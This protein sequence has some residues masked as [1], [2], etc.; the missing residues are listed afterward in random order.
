ME[1]KE[2]LKKLKEEIEKLYGKRFKNIVLYGSWVRGEEQGR[3]SCVK[4]VKSLLKRAKRYLKI[5]ELLL[6]D[7]DYESSVSRAI[8]KECD[9]QWDFHRRSILNL[10]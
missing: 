10:V 3:Y 7:G 5:A 2:V 4:E 1:R 8:F 9:L 6:K